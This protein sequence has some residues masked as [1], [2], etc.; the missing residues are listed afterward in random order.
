M[1][2]HSTLTADQPTLFDPNPTPQPETP[3]KPAQPPTAGAHTLQLPK[4]WTP[5]PC[6][7]TCLTCRRP[8]GLGIC[9]DG[10]CAIVCGPPNR[11]G[12]V[13]VCL[14]T[15][16]VHARLTADRAVLTCPHCGHTHWHQPTPGRT[17]RT[18]HCG[19]PYILTIHEPENTQ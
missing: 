13:E 8:E 3:H 12:P 18:G 1:S 5:T 2:R 10:Q 4:P 11:R 6:T 9:P 14:L 17:W 16:T 19:K 7:P 15:T